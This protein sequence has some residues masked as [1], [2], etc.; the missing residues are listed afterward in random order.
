MPQVTIEKLVFGGQGMGRMGERVV[1]VTGGY[2]GETVE[3]TPTKQK[4]NFVEG[5]VANV[6]T[7]SPD[8]IASVDDHFMSCSPWQTLSYAAENK[9]KIEIA[10]ETYRRLGKLELSNLVIESPDEQ[11]HYRNKMEYNFYIDAPTSPN[12]SSGSRGDQLYFAFHDRGTHHLRPIGECVLASLEIQEAGAR[13]LNFLNKYKV[14]RR[15]LKS[16]II[17]S[18]GYG[19]SAVA[20]FIKD[21]MDLP[22]TELLSNKTLGVQLY[23]SDYRSPASVPTEL[24]QSAGQNFLETYI[25]GVNLRFGLLSFFQVNKSIFEKVIT[26]IHPWVAGKKIVDYYSG[27]GAIGLAIAKDAA[28]VTLVEEN[29]EA[30]DLAQH[31]IQANSIS[32]A[33]AYRARSEDSLEYIAPDSTVI[34]DP[35]RTGLH[36]SV[37]E[38]FLEI[39][40]ERII[41]LSCGIDTQARDVGQLLSAYRP[42]FSQLYNFFP[43]TPHIEGLVVLERI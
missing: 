33:T 2:P 26:A 31:N 19:H 1:F 10:K 3:F 40:P 39:Q 27:V 32:N 37:I 5:V 38:R 42:V 36:G 30:V 43:R 12:P 17:R 15:S 22:I 9:W 25:D 29:A 7:P 28:S 6:I 20:L 35:P 8:R 14:P 34:V 4:K 41:Y 11:Y 18:D 13:V 23:L 24:L 16:A 21:K